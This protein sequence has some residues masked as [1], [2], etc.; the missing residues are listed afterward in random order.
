MSNLAAQL[1][2]TL[3]I[4]KI[5]LGIT[6]AAPI[7][8]VSIEM[9]KRG[10]RHGFLSAFTVRLGGALGNTL[11]L[12]ATYYGLSQ[13]LAHGFL[14]T[15]MGALGAC[16]LIY[17]GLKTLRKGEKDLNLQAPVK[18]NNAL[19]WGLYLSIANPI[20]FVFW[21]GLF[22]TTLDPQTGVTFSG[23][24]ANLFIIFG[25]LLWGAL[26]SLFLAF[27]HRKL[28]KKIIVYLSKAAGVVMIYFGVTYVIQV[29]QRI[30]T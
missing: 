14:L 26:L 4:E 18:M 29:V 22:A 11:C 2:T 21:P 28:D 20:A 9:I 12:V 13:I 19:L 25:V 8:P 1:S 3:I 30:I 6:L 27:G 7:G 23:F 5:I 24:V 16:L 15:L 10:L 17:M